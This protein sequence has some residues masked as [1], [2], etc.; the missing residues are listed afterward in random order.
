MKRLQS[1]LCLSLLTLP[2]AAAAEQLPN[3]PRGLMEMANECRLRFKAA[4]YFGLLTDETD[5][6]GRADQALAI[7][8]MREARDGLGLSRSEIDEEI[9]ELA[10]EYWRQFATP[11]RTFEADDDARTKIMAEARRC[12]DQTKAVSQRS[13]SLA[14]YRTASTCHA[15]IQPL[16]KRLNEEP[17]LAKEAA[18]DPE[19]LKTLDRYGEKALEQEAKALGYGKA[20]VHERVERERQRVWKE[21]EEEGITAHSWEAHLRPILER[22][23]QSAQ[24]EGAIQ[25][26]RN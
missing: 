18:I 15:T 7:V 11:N 3:A 13:F 16:R 4:T 14:R 21:V 1:L 8:I 10:V 23:L 19:L 22:C 5:A 2:S 24:L 26:M 17:A 12:L 20:R 25:Q 6:L 9:Q